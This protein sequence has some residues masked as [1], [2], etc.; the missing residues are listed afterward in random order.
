MKLEQRHREI[1]NLETIIK[2]LITDK[3]EVEYRIGSDPL[4]KYGQDIIGGKPISYD[5]IGNCKTSDLPSSLEIAFYNT[6]FH[7]NKKLNFGD[8]NILDLI[9]KKN[10]FEV[11]ITISFSYEDTVESDVNPLRLIKLFIGYAEEAGFE[12]SDFYEMER[13][14]WF[15]MFSA[16]FYHCS[17]CNQ[18]TSVE[19]LYD[20]IEAF[21]RL[22]NKSASEMH[23]GLGKSIRNNKNRLG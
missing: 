16:T 8:F 10:K 7:F 15:D 19:K 5:L 2:K 9:K 11:G 23:K 13:N 14:E 3:V 20:A 18:Q 22:L 17:E 4:I 12:R 1:N 21:N 6:R